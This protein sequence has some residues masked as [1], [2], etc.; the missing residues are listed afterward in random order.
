MF[1]YASMAGTLPQLNA[2]DFK[3]FRDRLVADCGDPADPIAVMLIE[4]IALAHLNIGRLQYKSANAGSLEE[5]RAYGG[6]ATQLLGEF[7]RTALALQA[8]RLAAMPAG[9]RG[10][11]P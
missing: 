5:A 8:Y 9:V 3:A 4:Q 10:E 2:Q 6:L 1:L 7:R 11:N